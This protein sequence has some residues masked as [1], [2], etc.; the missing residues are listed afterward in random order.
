MTQD[1]L[2]AFR[3]GLSLVR[4]LRSL[5]LLG[6]RRGTQQ[7]PEDG[8]WDHQQRAARTRLEWNQSTP[9]WKNGRP[10]LTPWTARHR[11][12][13]PTRL[14]S[15]TSGRAQSWPEPEREGR[16][17]GQDSHEEIAISRGDGKVRWKRSSRHL[18]KQKRQPH[19]PKRIQQD[20][21]EQRSSR[22]RFDKRGITYQITISVKESRLGPHTE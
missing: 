21:R 1:H 14:N 13:I 5:A 16:K 15:Q 11:S 4:K 12:M 9:T 6:G 2:A 8:D 18:W 17:P 19:G 3:T 10:V 7:E 20:Q 22:G